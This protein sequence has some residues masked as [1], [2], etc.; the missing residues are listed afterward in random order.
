MTG[1]WEN[2]SVSLQLFCKPKIPSKTNK[3]QVFWGW[4]TTPSIKRGK[5]LQ[6]PVWPWNVLTEWCRQQYGCCKTKEIPKRGMWERDLTP[7]SGHMMNLDDSGLLGTWSGLTVPSNYRTHIP[8][9]EPISPP[10]THS[11]HTPTASCDSHCAHQQ[12]RCQRG[13]PKNF[14]CRLRSFFFEAHNKSSLLKE[15]RNIRNT[16]SQQSKGRRITSW[17]AAELGFRFR[18]ALLGRPY[19]SHHTTGP[20]TVSLVWSATLTNT[21]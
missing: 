9:K 1:K 14:L 15:R 13:F 19:P 11:T 16:N 7:T 12:E 5:P 3:T 8:C 4:F 10:I 21:S 18:S 2:S 6:V 20:H 17:W